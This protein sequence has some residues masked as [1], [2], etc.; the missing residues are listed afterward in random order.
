MNEIQTNLLREMGV[1][2]CP[3]C[4]LYVGHMVEIRVDDEGKERILTA[5]SVGGAILLRGE[6]WCHFC[7]HPWFWESSRRR[8]L[9]RR[10][11]VSAV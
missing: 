3:Q 8:I 2:F 4:R 6:G 11:R 7:K 10:A 5:L 9:V 1:A